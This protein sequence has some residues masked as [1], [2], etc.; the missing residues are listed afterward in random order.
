[1][2]GVQMTIISVTVNATLGIVLALWVSQCHV[3]VSSL[4]NKGNRIVQESMV[5]NEKSS[6]PQQMERLT[7]ALAGEW[8]AD[9]TY[10]PSDLLPTGGKGHSV[11]SYRIGPAGLSL[12]QEYHGDG[13]TGKSW[14]TGIIWWDSAVPGFHFVWC[15]TYALDRGC[16][17]SSQI[18]KWEGDD[19]VQTDTHEVS[20][21]RVFEKEVWS[22]FTQ[23]SFVQ[24]LYVGE[25]PDRLKRFMTVTAKRS[26]NQ[27]KVK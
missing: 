17:V 13:A 8:I 19:F 21:K 3:V 7:R 20:G 4:A 11:E 22:N 26:S 14:G 27:Q 12:I 25:A 24:T 2:H 15:D 10:D 1:M 18:G 9:E 5:E 23:N 16:R 6:S